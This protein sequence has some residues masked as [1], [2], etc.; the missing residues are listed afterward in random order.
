VNAYL[1][2]D[3]VVQQTMV[4]IAQLATAGG[5]RAPL[6]HI[7][8]QVFIDLTTELQNLGVKKNVIADMFG[9]ALRTYHRRVHELAQSKTD[10]GKSVWEAVLAFIRQNEPASGYDVLARFSG[11][12]PDVVTGVLGDL[13]QSGLVYRAG[14]GESARYRIAAD[15]DFSAGDE[16]RVAAREHLVWLAV[17]RNGPLTAEAICSLTRVDRAACDAALHAL[18]RDARVVEKR[19]DAGATYAADN[20]VVP[21]GDAKGWEAAVLDHFQAMVTAI[22]AKLNQ[23]APRGSVSDLIGGSTWTLDVW[24]GHPFE[25]E[26]KALLRATRATVEALRTRVDAHNAG[27]ASPPPHERVVFY[28]GQYVREGTTSFH[29]GDPFHDDDEEYR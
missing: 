8:E 6:A 23:R 13:A 11:D 4:F 29:A 27:V 15:A 19:A 3:A 17:Y 26:A 1:L 10:S 25:A 20:F 7:A 21:L 16:T 14:R 18:M 24:P 2:V 5:V 12:D 28:A 9:L 22:I